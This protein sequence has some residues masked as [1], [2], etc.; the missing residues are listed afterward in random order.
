LV[1]SL[2]VVGRSCLLT[3]HIGK[4]AIRTKAPKEVTELIT[5]MKL[6]VEKES[7]SPKKANEI[8]ALIFKLGVKIVYLTQKGDLNIGDVLIADEPIRKALDLFIRCRNHVVDRAESRD[9][10]HT[11]ILTPMR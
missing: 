9:R 11:V 7:G 6:L 4:R 2:A 3:S 5:A 1:Y 10:R 8:E